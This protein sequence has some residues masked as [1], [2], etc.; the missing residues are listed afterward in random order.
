MLE[1]YIILVRSKLQKTLFPLLLLLVSIYMNESPIGLREVPPES[2]V[3]LFV[4]VDLM[5]FD[6]LP[7]PFLSLHFITQFCNKK[8]PLLG[9]FNTF[10]ICYLKF[11][12]I[13]EI[14]SIISNRYFEI[15]L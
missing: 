3:G 15:V 14:I 11:I 12:I 2:P 5:K 1:I 10:G 9:D 4:F 13:G 8:D 7:F 6:I